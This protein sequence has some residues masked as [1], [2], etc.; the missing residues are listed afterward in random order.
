MFISC[1]QCN[2]K[3]TID[4]NLIPQEGRLLQCG[5]CN[6]KWF[7]KKKIDKIPLE[8]INDNKKTSQKRLKNNNQI[9]DINI[10]NSEF[11]NAG[12]NTV[13]SPI[14]KIYTI[15]TLFRL[16]IVFIISFTTLVIIL[17]TF[18]SSLKVPFPEIEFMLQSLYETLIDIFLFVK[19]FFK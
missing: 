4:S 2:K 8:D 14:K 18:K 6:N 1:D 19:D 11:Y 3:F 9:N 12:D 15:F 17:D 10:E 16:I 13:K 5:F 7:Y